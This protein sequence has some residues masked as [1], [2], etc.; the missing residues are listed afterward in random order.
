MWHTIGARTAA[1][2]GLLQSRTGLG[3]NGLSRYEMRGCGRGVLGVGAFCEVGLENHV[4]AV[5]DIEWDMERWSA[6]EDLVS[7]E[8]DILSWPFIS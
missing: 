6:G 4:A 7:E 1:A 8:D 2:A 3:G 5:G